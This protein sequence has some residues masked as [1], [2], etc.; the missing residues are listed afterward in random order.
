MSWWDVFIIAFIA[1]ALWRGYKK[2][3]ALRLG[4][5]VGA[6]LLF[7]ILWHNMDVVDRA[8]SARVNGRDMVAGWI[9][10]YLEKRREGG[11]DVFDTSALRDLINTLPLPAGIEDSLIGQIDASTAAAS[12]HVYD[13]VAQTLAIPVWHLLLFLLTWAAAIFIFYVLGRL[14]K[15]GLTKVP[16]LETFDRFA[17]AFF[18]SFLSLVLLAVIGSIG[19]II[20]PQEVITAID[21]SFFAT[22]LH[23]ALIFLL[24]GPAILS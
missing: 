14:V 23:S 24:G 12:A 18:S 21:N 1:F 4:G 10:N 15:T 5:W 11:Q 3:L 8:V 13:Y 2:G 16:V 6:T 9:H 17:G 7:I 19:S 22:F 20:A